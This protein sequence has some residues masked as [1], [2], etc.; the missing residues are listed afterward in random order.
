MNGARRSGPSSAAA[1]EDPYLWL[2]EITGD[3]ALAWVNEQNDRSV[4]ALSAKPIFKELRARFRS[5][6]DSEQKIES[7]LVLGD[8]FYNFWKDAEHPR[9]V[10]R[11]ASRAEYGKPKPAWEVV[12]D[13]DALAAAEHEN[14]VWQD[15]RCLRPRYERCLITLSRGGAD[16]HVVRELATDLISRK[17]TSPERL[18]IAGGSNGGLLVGVML[19][20]RPDLFGAVVCIAPHLDMKRYTKHPTGPSFIDEFG[21][22]DVPEDWAAM[23]KYS[24]YQNV[25][26]GTRYPPTLFMTSTRDDRGFPGDPRKMTARMQADGDDV[27]FY[28]NPEGGHHGAANNEQRAFEQAMIYSFLIE[29]LH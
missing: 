13:L 24:P 16:A 1:S 2:E 6:L 27:L 4:G 15:P 23:A 5:I 29:H 22:P 11:R 9:G 3:R 26:R 12:L 7:P 19:T 25:H 17:V 14:W 20:E 18:G 8:H 28:E 10:W 21:D